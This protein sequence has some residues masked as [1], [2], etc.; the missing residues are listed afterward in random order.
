MRTGCTGVG[1][2]LPL[3]GDKKAFL[4]AHMGKGCSFQTDSW[5][6]GLDLAQA[7]EVMAALSPV[8]LVRVTQSLWGGAAVSG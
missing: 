7:D 1:T 4:G 5:N 3:A 2:S 8:L 6:G